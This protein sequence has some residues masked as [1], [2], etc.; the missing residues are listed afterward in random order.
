[1]GSSAHPKEKSWL[2]P[3]KGENKGPELDRR[4][5]LRCLHPAR[6]VVAAAVAVKAAEAK[7]GR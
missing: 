2:R 5:F 1:M 7:S 6:I 4:G 3:A